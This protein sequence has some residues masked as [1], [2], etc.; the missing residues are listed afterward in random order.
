MPQIIRI[1]KDLIYICIR[2]KGG[3]ASG[4]PGEVYGYWEAYKLGGSLPWS[5]LFE[6]AIRMC[7]DGFRVPKALET[8]IR[9][10][11]QAIRNDV[12]L[13]NIYINKTSN[14]TY[15]FDDLIVMPKLARTLQIISEQN[16]TAF[17]NGALTK[18]MVE[19][20]NENGL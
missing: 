11:E 6:P 8:A 10:N 13:S 1:V 3:L 5:V 17:Y 19:E 9:L 2:I 20:I 15:K 14:Q 7:Q 18:L 4:I 16:I 12:E